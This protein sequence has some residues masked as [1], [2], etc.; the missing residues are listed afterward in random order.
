MPANTLQ[1]TWTDANWA[2]VQKTVHDEAARLRVARQ[3]LSL[4]TPADAATISAD[5]IHMN[6]RAWPERGIEIRTKTT[7]IVELAVNVFLT[8]QAA[9]E[10]DLH[11][12]I[13]LF[14]Y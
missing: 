10:S 9:A 14:T 4:Q 12:A 6:E 11:S 13:S 5:L 3:F 2:L 1:L 7:E 8:P